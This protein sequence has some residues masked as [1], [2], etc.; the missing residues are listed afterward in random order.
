MAATCE[1]RYGAVS[2]NLAP[3]KSTAVRSV[4]DAMTS[5]PAGRVELHDA[6][7]RRRWSVDVAPFLLASVPVTR[8]DWAA[9]T[10][11][12][13][14]SGALEPMTEVS[15]LDAVGF[16]NRLSDAAGLAVC[17]AIEGDQVA[18]DPAAEGYRLPTEAE[19]EHACR[20]GADPDPA[21][22]DSVA[23]YR[24]NAGERVHDV[25][26]RAPNAWGLH[27][28]LGNVWEWCWDLLDAEVYREY[29]VFRGGG[30]ADPPWSCRPSVRRGSHPT[31]RIDDL[32]LRVA[33]T[34]GAR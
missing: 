15:W 28:M 4:P 1:R 22:L 19:W 29:R 30:W 26:T 31:F 34:P 8:G 20:A 6:R 14:A 2:M 25:G 23:W 27:D 16:C 5:V 7:S 33:R 12:A 21:E 32:G 18:W 13:V 24:D 3:S 10:G 9:I 11:G 17:Y